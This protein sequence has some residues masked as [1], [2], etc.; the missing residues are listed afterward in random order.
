MKKAG[1]DAWVE[2]AGGDIEIGEAGGELEA[3]TH[4]GNIRVWQAGSTV[5]ARTAGGRIEVVNAKGVVVA[6]N[7]G[8]SIQVGSSQGCRCESTGGSIRLR[9]TAGALR[10][11]TD[12]GSIL[13]ELA[14]GLLLQDS[15]L[16]TGAGD[17]TVFI[18]SNIAL[19]IKA[20]NE[21]GRAG[22]IVSEFTEVAVRRPGVAEGAL[23]GG[24]PV[25]RLTSFD[26]T[27]YLR[28]KLQ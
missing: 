2:T 21:T 19:T 3:S 27:I 7:S 28:R 18:P 25:L 13:A 26:G 22:R 23:N 24:G 12:V 11:A 16:S 1:G 15:V 14:P 20:L 8:G 4:G 5:A 10:A 17:I 9:G 6:G